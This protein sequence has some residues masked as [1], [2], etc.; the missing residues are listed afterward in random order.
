MDT[1]SHTVLGACIG[2]VTLGKKI[3]KKGMLWGAIA[4]NF[5]DIDVLFSLFFHPVD[6][7][8]VHRGI[9]HSFLFVSVMSL[10]LGYIF[11]KTFKNQPAFYGDWFRLFF[12]ALLSHLLL[13]SCTVY[14]TGIFEPFSSYRFQFTSLFIIDPLYT[15]SLL[16]AVIALLILKKDSLK[17]NFWWK[18][19]IYLST[20]YFLFAIGNKLYMEKIFANSLKEQSVSV[21]EQITSP[22]ALNNILW[23]VVAKDTHGYWIGFYSHFD[24]NKKIDFS[25]IPRNDSLAGELLHNKAVQKLI[26]FSNGYYCFTQCHDTIYFNDLRFAFA[27]QFHFRQHDLIDRKHVF[28]F[29]LGMI[30]DPTAPYGIHFERNAWSRNRFKG[31]SNLVRRIK[32]I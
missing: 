7:L 12:I 20:L 19:G 3:G 24:K 8:L 10:L 29:S 31:F 32:G 22:T 30:K 17:R 14:G 4:A 23:N 9:T 28:V 5:P 15:L 18:F 21:K 13:D 27:G 25:F 6:A 1:L 2:E 11:Y 26:K 16:I